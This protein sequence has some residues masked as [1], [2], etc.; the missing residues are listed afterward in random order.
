MII[1]NF[2][3][4][5]YI[6]RTN[7]PKNRK[8]THFNLLRQGKHH[9]KK[10]Q[11]DFNIYGEE[12]FEFVILKENVSNSEEEELK[13]IYSNDNG[14]NMIKQSK[15]VS[16]YIHHGESNGMYGKKHSEESKIRMSESTKGMYNGEKNPF[17]GKKHSEESRRKMSESKKGQG[18]NIPKS[19]SHREKIKM[20]NPKRKPV[21]ID[22]VKYNSINEASKILGIDRKTITYRLNSKNFKNYNY[23]E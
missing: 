22:D 21:I 2:N 16:N 4:K 12:N 1:N 9:S 8:A 23:D 14:Y 18:E 19:D 15:G 3:K 17:Y 10:M 5:K 11:D 6:G 7:N 20:S 13:M